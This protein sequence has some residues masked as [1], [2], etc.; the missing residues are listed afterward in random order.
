MSWPAPQVSRLYRSSAPQVNCGRSDVAAPPV[1][2]AKRVTDRESRDE[3]RS[4]RRPEHFGEAFS[5]RKSSKPQ[6]GLAERRENRSLCGAAMQGSARN[7]RGCR[8]CRQPEEPP[9]PLQSGAFRSFRAALHFS[10]HRRLPGRSP[11]CPVFFPS[12]AISNIICPSSSAQP[13]SF[14]CLSCPR[15]TK[16][17]SSTGGRTDAQPL[18]WIRTTAPSWTPV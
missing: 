18:F 7:S 15:G 6:S 11:E 8:H 13:S 9:V 1:V 2:S 5:N 3:S 12:A 16:A 10:L 14:S 17:F 4:V